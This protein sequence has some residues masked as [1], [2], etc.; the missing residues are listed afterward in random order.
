MKAPVS[1]PGIASL[2]DGFDT[3]FLD[4]FGVLHDGAAPYPGV[5]DCLWAMRAAGSKIVILSNSGKRAAENE[6]RMMQL[7]FEPGMWDLFL[8]SGEAAW[9]MFAD[10]TD[11]KAGMKCL[12]ISR[13]DDRSA[14]EGF[15]LELVEDAANAD[16]IL[17]T[18]SEG[19][20]LELDHYRRTLA[21]GARSGVPCI[22][23]NP[24]K[25]MLTR[26]GPKFA[27]GRIA[28][29]YEEMGG[30]VTW[31]GKPFPAIYEAALKAMGSPPRER[32]LCVGDSPEHDIAGAKSA[33]LASAL[34]RTGIHAELSDAE[35]QTRWEQ[36]KAAPDFILPG[37]IWQ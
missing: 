7:G 18:A 1:M 5:L 6:R 2:V 11:F 16:V 26:A 12:L 3:Y 10:G 29:L 20:R 13:D 22:C 19:D 34:V 8:S 30:R 36:H 25:V 37:L 21:A 32:V 9:R 15:G 23:T 31:I 27:A 17:L 28:E 33:G 4:Q 14:I 24:D 35:L